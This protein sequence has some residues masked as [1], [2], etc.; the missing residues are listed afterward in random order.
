M[1]TMVCIGDS[2]TEGTDIPTGHTWP[3]L[4]AND[5]GLDVINCGIGGDTT[6][7]MLSRFYPE[8]VA[9]KPAFVFIMGGTNDLWWNWEV[10]TILGNLFSMIVQARH[11][12]IAP[13]IGLPIPVNVTAARANDISPP[14]GGY[15]RLNKKMAAMV[16]EL[17]RHATASEVSAIDLYHPFLTE[18]RQVRTDLFLPD[19][20]HPNK[21]GHRAIAR[22]IASAFRQDLNFP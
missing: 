17:I 19:G 20:L 18:N 4:V 5:L 15:D 6:T 11:H 9:S 22:A 2:L 14:Q 10:N 3:A 16:E 21:A 12:G 7:G 1:K 13:V 8:V